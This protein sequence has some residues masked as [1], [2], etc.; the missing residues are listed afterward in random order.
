MERVENAMAEA[1]DQP[2]RRVGAKATKSYEEFVSYDNPLG[3]VGKVH[4]EFE[5]EMDDDE[6]SDLTYAFQAVSGGT[7]IYDR[8]SSGLG[9]TCGLAAH[10]S[11]LTVPT[12]APTPG[13]HG[14]RRNDRSVRA[15]RNDL[16]A[17]RNGDTTPLL[18]LLLVSL[19]LLL[20]LSASCHVNR[21]IPPTNFLLLLRSAAGH[22]GAGGRAARGRQGSL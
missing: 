5:H 11:R 14:R 22:D 20:R 9:I 19:L 10:A 2:N 18:R 6:L 7:D 21:L 13:G 17:R 1:S 3:E 15:L 12:L 16:R 4:A 8:F